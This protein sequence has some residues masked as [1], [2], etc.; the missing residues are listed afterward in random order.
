M[1]QIRR[2]TTVRMARRGMATMTKSH[3]QHAAFSS[4]GAAE[5]CLSPAA[6][7]AEI[8]KSIHLIITLLACLQLVVNNQSVVL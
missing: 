2:P 4:W 7:D 5:S 3:L 1:I 6:I 8:Q